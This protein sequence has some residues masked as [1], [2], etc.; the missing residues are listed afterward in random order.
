MG[1]VPPAMSGFDQQNPQPEKK[2]NTVLWV[3]LAVVVGGGCFFCILLAAV[4]VPVFAQ[5]RKAA[6]TTK[7]LSNVKQIGT[8]ML[9]YAAD[10]ND[11]FP[12]ADNWQTGVMPYLKDPELFIPPYPTEPG[13]YAFNKSLS[14]FNSATL[15]N[16]FRTPLVFE[17]SQAG[18][19]L[20]GGVEILR[21]IDKR[22]V[23]GHAD[24]SARRYEVPD[25]EA[26]E[27]VV[28]PKK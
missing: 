12:K 2:K 26:L 27:W 8:G 9:M 17:S 16:P 25:A 7:S 4:L 5:A 21:K 10:Y 18:E 22:V 20:S 1:Q 3:V 19:N 11:V 15:D 28:T 6:H 14:S 13:G 23:V 24:S